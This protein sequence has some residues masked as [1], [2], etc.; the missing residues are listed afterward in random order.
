MRQQ[1]PLGIPKPADS[2]LAA[3]SLVFFP[4]ESPVSLDNQTQWW[5]WKTDINW[6]HPDGGENS[7]EKTRTIP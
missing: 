3:G 2:L 1:L 4:P 7:F 6:K 5:M